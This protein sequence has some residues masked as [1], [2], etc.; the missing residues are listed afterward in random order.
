MYHTSHCMFTTCYM[1]TGQAGA[2]VPRRRFKAEC[3]ETKK[4]CSTVTIVCGHKLN[5]QVSGFC[6]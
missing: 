6:D 2:P 5:T 3:A 4:I 1:F